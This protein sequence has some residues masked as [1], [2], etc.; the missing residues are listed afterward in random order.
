MT[1][2]PHSPRGARDHPRLHRAQCGAGTRRPTHRDRAAARHCAI[3]ASPLRNAAQFG[4][5]IGEAMVA[6]VDQDQLL[7]LPRASARNRS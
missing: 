6:R 7:R 1:S 2:S 3:Q 5:P 4:A